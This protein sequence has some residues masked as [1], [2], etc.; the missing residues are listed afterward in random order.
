VQFLADG[1][2]E[3]CRTS[4]DFTAQASGRCDGTDARRGRL[5]S[6]VLERIL[7][8]ST[9]NMVSLECVCRQALLCTPG[10]IPLTYGKGTCA[11]SDVVRMYASPLHTAFSPSRTSMV[12][13]FPPSACLGDVNDPALVP[14]AVGLD[15]RTDERTKAREEACGD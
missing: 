9:R 13:H 3:A 11:S 5:V 12:L 2:Q 8:L 15:A 10:L 6:V 7:D 1:N 4:F 14:L